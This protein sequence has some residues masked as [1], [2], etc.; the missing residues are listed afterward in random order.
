MDTENPQAEDNKLVNHCAAYGHS[1]LINLV[2]ACSNFSSRMAP[3]PLSRNPLSRNPSD[4]SSSSS[5]QPH[6]RLF[7]RENVENNEYRRLIGW[8]LDSP[9]PLWQHDNSCIRLPS[10]FVRWLVGTLHSLLLRATDLVSSIF[11]GLDNTIRYLESAIGGF[12][13]TLC[14][15]I[16]RP[17]GIVIWF[18][19]L[20]TM[21][22]N[23]SLVGIALSR[24]ESTSVLLPVECASMI[25]WA[26]LTSIVTGRD[27][28]PE[29]DNAV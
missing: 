25:L 13:N 26:L 10:Q 4:Y 21:V 23:G 12:S 14:E 24:K 11:L 22:V 2:K 9:T 3:M 28:S 29:R 7:G 17:L 15:C 27:A 5:G 8:N 18:C 19:L 16:P 1:E 20:A 6:F